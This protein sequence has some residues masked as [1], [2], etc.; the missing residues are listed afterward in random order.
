MTHA[1]DASRFPQGGTTAVADALLAVDTILADASG[2]GR[3]VCY[4]LEGDTT[5]LTREEIE[6]WIV[7][8]EAEGITRIRYHVAGGDAAV[9][10]VTM[11]P[12][13]SAGPR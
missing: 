4:T 2:A 12:V 5:V 7:G 9:V 3:R 10:H 6:A 11:G 8:V 1:A 13:E